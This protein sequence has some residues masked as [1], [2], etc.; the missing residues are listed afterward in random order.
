M[1]VKE[2]EMKATGGAPRAH[3]VRGPGGRVI[4]IFWG[5]DA[6][7]EAASWAARGYQVQTADRE[8]VAS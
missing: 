4:V 3:V 5:D 7:S 8:L 1:S 2:D 6:E